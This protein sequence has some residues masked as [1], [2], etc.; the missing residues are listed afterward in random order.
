M[1]DWYESD[2]NL[3]D[4]IVIST[5]L[6]GTMINFSSAL[7]LASVAKTASLIKT[8][9]SVA[10]TIGGI[11]GGGGFSGGGHGGGGGGSW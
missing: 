10:G 4:F 8:I 2:A 9:G 3:I 5:L 11:G 1:P 7:H 6:R